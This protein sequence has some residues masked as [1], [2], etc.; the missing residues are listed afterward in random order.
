VLPKSDTIFINPYKNFKHRNSCH[1]IPYTN[2]L[3][4]FGIPKN[5]VRLIK[6]CLNLTYSKFHV[7]KLLSDTFRI[8]NGLKR[9]DALSPLLFNFALEYTIR[10][11][12]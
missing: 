11:F 6:M 7:G 2:I 4:E 5:L 1:C 3:L 8:H 9:G 10:R 12:Q